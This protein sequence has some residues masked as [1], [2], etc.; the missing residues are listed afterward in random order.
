[1]QQTVMEERVPI[2]VTL[3]FSACRRPID[4]QMCGTHPIDAVIP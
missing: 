1:M 4:S 3:V 2:R